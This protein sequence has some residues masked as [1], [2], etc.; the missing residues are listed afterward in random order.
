MER[1]IQLNKDALIPD[2]RNTDIVIC[3]N[4]ILQD[5]FGLNTFSILQLP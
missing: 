5:V 2:V 3:D 4:H 1:Y